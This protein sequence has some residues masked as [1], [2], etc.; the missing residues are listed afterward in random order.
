[1]TRDDPGGLQ[2]LLRFISLSSGTSTAQ[3]MFLS[4]PVKMEEKQKKQM[5][6]RVLRAPLSVCSHQRVP[7]V[8]LR[9]SQRSGWL[10]F[11]IWPGERRVLRT[12]VR[13]LKN[14]PSKITPQ[15]MV[16]F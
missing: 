5:R 13:K 14:G 11:D 4:L 6:R 7:Q 12:T 15:R 1:M 8:D 3:G 16:E 9:K 10:N 2:R